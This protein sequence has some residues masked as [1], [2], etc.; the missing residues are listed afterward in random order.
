[1]Q[2]Q[3]PG[4]VDSVVFHGRRNTSVETQSAQYSIALFVASDATDTWQC[5]CDTVTQHKAVLHSGLNQL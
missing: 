5:C 1:M 2:A 4:F 3:Q